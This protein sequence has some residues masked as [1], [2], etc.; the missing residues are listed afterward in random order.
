MAKICTVFINFISFDVKFGQTDRLIRFRL[1]AFIKET[2]LSSLAEYKGVADC[3]D[4][5]DEVFAF[6]TEISMDCGT[7]AN[8]LS[9]LADCHFRSVFCTL[10]LKKTTCGS[11]EHILL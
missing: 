3:F 2:S 7:K 11:K 1:K 8:Q 4:E 5:G 10:F 9:E 6:D